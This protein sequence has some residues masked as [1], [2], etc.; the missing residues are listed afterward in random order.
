M[1]TTRNTLQAIA[2]A[3]PLRKVNVNSDLRYA[4]RTSLERQLREHPDEYALVK[5]I[6]PVTRA[7]Q[8]VVESRIDQS[9]L[10][11]QSTAVTPRYET[12][13]TVTCDPIH[14]N[15]FVARRKL[16]ARMG[17]TEHRLLKEDGA[18]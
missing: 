18:R 17:A 15:P 10:D 9:R 6:G 3:N 13:P 5:L 1:S 2:R 12:R 4:Y 11:G 8:D 7:V 14:T 16:L